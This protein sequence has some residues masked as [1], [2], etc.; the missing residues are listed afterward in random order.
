MR[1]VSTFRVERGN[2]AFEFSEI[3][4][5]VMAELE[6]V[7]LSGRYILSDEVDR[8][9]QAFSDY[10]G[11]SHTLGV[12]S[13]TDALYLA[14]R[15]LGIGAGDE[16]IT[17]A[18][19]FHATALAIANVGARTV[20]VDARADDFQMDSTR[21][22]AAI[23]PRTKAILA[24]HLFGK[25]LD[26]TPLM[27]LCERYGLF[28]VEDCAQATGASIGGRKVGSFGDIACFSFHPSKTLAA[29]GDAGALTTN[30]IELA[31]RV[32]SLRYF[33]QRESKVHSELGCNSKLDSVQAI[34]L[35]HKLRLL[36]HWN[37]LRRT[38]ARRY[39]AG[40]ADLPLRFQAVGQNEGHVYHLFQISLEGPGR[41]SLLSHLVSQGIDAIV[42]YPVP[43]H[44]QPAFQNL[45][46]ERGAFPVSERLA[47]ANLCLPLRP[48][49]SS[50]ESELVIGAVREFFGHSH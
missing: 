12:N 9:E 41:D 20:L 47:N 10:V 45:G 49:M 34:V 6:S 27:Q 28:L 24:V 32:R 8:F 37:E 43:I 13:G 4:S 30:N 23:S 11:C 21:I 15:A 22:E 18:N 26:I 50:D 1:S 48:D 39:I 2:F 42:R 29:A 7:L 5:P 44:L 17:V 16:V 33:G 40:L 35:F 14:L 36:D 31:A 25:P 19:T 3:I 38:Q 46:Y